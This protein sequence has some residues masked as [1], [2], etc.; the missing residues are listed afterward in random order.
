M[1]SRGS[2]QRATDADRS[3]RPPPGAEASEPDR[4]RY[5]EHGSRSGAPQAEVQLARVLFPGVLQ[6]EQQ[7]GALSRSQHS[8]AAASHQVRRQQ[9]DLGC[10]QWFSPRG[11]AIADQSGRH[12]GGN[13]RSG[14]VIEPYIVA[15]AQ[16]TDE[17]IR[18]GHGQGG[19]RVLPVDLYSRSSGEGVIAMEKIPGV[20]GD[21]LAAAGGPGRNEYGVVVRGGGQTQVIDQMDYRF[22]GRTGRLTPASVGRLQGHDDPCQRLPCTGARLDLPGIA[23]VIVAQRLRQQ[24]A[25][26]SAPPSP[27]QQRHGAQ[28]VDGHGGGPIQVPRIPQPQEGGPPLQ[29]NAQRHQ[30]LTTF[31]QDQAAVPA[32]PH[33]PN[34]VMTETYGG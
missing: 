16:M 26:I 32:F 11:C 27:G 17:S 20:E 1:S 21:H 29:A 18:P 31:P 14:T 24:P 34:R 10:S 2:I 15:V 33:S 30:G 5:L 3:R 28:Q 4:G 9:V 8:T 25:E 12:L 13:P 23:E 6:S 19:D 22:P 7:S